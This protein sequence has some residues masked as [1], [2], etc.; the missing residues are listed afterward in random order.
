VVF[1]AREGQARPLLKRK[2]QGH[3]APATGFSQL[4][5]SERWDVDGAFVIVSLL[6]ES[7]GALA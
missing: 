1:A 7:F 6:E 4:D 3:M 2:A 5:E